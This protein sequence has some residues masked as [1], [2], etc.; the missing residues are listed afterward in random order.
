MEC[1]RSMIVGNDAVTA[2]DDTNATA[3]GMNVDGDDN[4][5]VSTSDIPNENRCSAAIP[6]PVAQMNIDG[7][8]YL[9]NIIHRLAS[10]LKSNQNQKKKNRIQTSEKKKVITKQFKCGQCDYKSAN[11][12]RINAHAQ[13][14][15]TVK[16]FNCDACNVHFKYKRSL[17][18]HMGNHHNVI[19]L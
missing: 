17:K 16:P 2:G 5:V 11:K 8:P 6:E 1:E 18:V 7:K 19:L 14:H 3:D 9:Q 13:V 12:Y 4:A 10:N 15:S